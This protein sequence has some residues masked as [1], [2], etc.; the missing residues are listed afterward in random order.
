MRRVRSV[1]WWLGAAC[2]LA[3]PR[4]AQAPTRATSE[5]SAPL[6]PQRNGESWALL[7]GLARVTHV[8]LHV[9][10]GACERAAA[11][12]TREFTEQGVFAVSAPTLQVFEV[13][14]A[15]RAASGGAFDVAIGRACHRI[16]V[17]VMLGA[18]AWAAWTL[19]EEYR[20]AEPS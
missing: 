5:E 20:R 7:Q 17:V 10:S 3:L 14:G 16:G 4:Q 2:L 1:A 18:I 12:L 6:L 11:R 9:P 15:V 8:Q 19:R 13:A